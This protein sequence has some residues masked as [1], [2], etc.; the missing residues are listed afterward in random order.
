MTL[1]R[2]CFGT[3]TF[4]AGR[5]RPAK[6][7]APGMAALR[8]AVLSGVRLIHSN[9]KLDTQWA[10]RRVL[11]SL[12]NSS[13][14]QHLVKAEAPLGCGDGV[15]VR[16]VTA[17]INTSRERLGVDRLHAVVLEID[18]KRTVDPDLHRDA[19]AVRA[20]YRDGAPVALSTG[21]VDTVL[22]YC[23]LPAHLPPAL[24]CD[25]IT[26]VATPHNLIERWAS[27]YLGAISAAGKTF[28]GMSPLRRGTLVDVTAPT[29]SDRLAALRWALS[30]PRVAAVAI[31]MSSIEHLREVAEV[32]SASVAHRYLD[33]QARV[34]G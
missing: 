32:V 22:A 26:G 8:A 23:P 6:Y 17:A 4:V 19:D 16:N 12:D 18:V 24:M 15:L 27:G 31:T 13:D 1:D 20:F 28:F 2:L 14:V 7:S 34:C 10:V 30:D 9:P 3:S 11:D 5:L 25:P 29:L 33:G 21:R